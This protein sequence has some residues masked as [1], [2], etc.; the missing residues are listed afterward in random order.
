VNE[1]IPLA[2]FFLAGLAGGAGHCVGMCGPLVLWVASR[3]GA[4]R[5]GAAAALPHLEYHLG[6]GITYAALG[7]MAGGAGSVVNWGGALLGVQK[8]AAL[9][10]GSLVVLYATARLAGARVLERVE[11]KTATLRPVRALLR[12]G[13]GRPLVAGLALGLLPCGISW[14]AILL[15]TGTG[16]AAR[17]ALALAVFGAGTTPALLALGLAGNLVTRRRGAVERVAL[18]VLGAAGAWFLVQAIRAL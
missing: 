10:A 16:S 9:V 11:E 8:V 1:A 3:H 14:G 6:R 2:A 4:D 13:T 18:V 7:A 17:G 5:R 15:A 12:R